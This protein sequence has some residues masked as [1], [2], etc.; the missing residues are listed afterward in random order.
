[1]L[2]EE[3]VRHAYV[4]YYE[5]FAKRTEKARSS[6]ARLCSR[7]RI[8]IEILPL[9]YENPVQSWTAARN[10]CEGRRT[11]IRHVLLDISTMP[12][13]L[14]WIL[15]SFFRELN[16]HGTYVYNMPK[17]YHS[18]WLSRDPGDP[19]LIYK[20][21]GESKFGLK[22]VLLVVTGFDLERA[23]QLIDFFDPTETILAVQ[24]GPQYDNLRMNASRHREFFRGS[25][26]ITS[27]DVDAY[28]SDHGYSKL[29][30]AIAA[31]VGNGNIVMASLGPKLSAMA[32]FRIHM[33]HPQVGLTYTPSKDYNLK[34]SHGIGNTIRGDLF[35]APSYSGSP[36][37][38]STKPLVPGKL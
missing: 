23:Q 12:R 13:D 24:S 9:K 4:F 25:P 15:L 18:K 7:A 37:P 34:Y 20:L 17:G 35:C 32:L 2:A 26:D 19:R 6:V 10:F 3:Q 28:S 16:V 31:R 21:G 5:E 30:K 36:L 8:K 29:Q 27:F 1:M 33:S 22:T 38:S 14:I 11:Q